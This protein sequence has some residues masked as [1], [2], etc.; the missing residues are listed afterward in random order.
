[1]ILIIFS[2]ERIIAK[3]SPRK[4]GGERDPLILVR[5]RPQWGVLLAGEPPDEVQHHQHGQLEGEDK[6]PLRWN[7]LL[8]A[9]IRHIHGGPT[10]SAYQNLRYLFLQ[11]E[12][13]THLPLCCAPFQ[14][15]NNNNNATLLY[16]TAAIQKSLLIFESFSELKL[17]K[18]WNVCE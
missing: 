17:I 14:V 8:F 18:I 3:L 11:S 1:M 9:I 16:R 13:G 12:L 6:M 4:S 7:R 5:K 15:N 2:Y 10:I